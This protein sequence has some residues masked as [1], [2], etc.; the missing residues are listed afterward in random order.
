MQKWASYPHC[1]TSQAEPVLWPQERSAESSSSP[2]VPIC[3][4][5]SS[6][7]FSQRKSFLSLTDLVV[8]LRVSASARDGGVGKMLVVQISGTR[9]FPLRDRAFE[10]GTNALPNRGLRSSILCALD[11]IGCEQPS[12]YQLVICASFSSDSL[13]RKYQKGTKVHP[14]GTRNSEVV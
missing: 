14:Y 8:V 1:S 12:P 4:R 2:T 9:D 13:Q 5:S 11:R 3:I 10:S 6:A 7:E